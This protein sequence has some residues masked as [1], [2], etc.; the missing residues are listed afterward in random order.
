M[1]V[2]TTYK[3]IR[4]VSRGGGVKASATISRH[5][6]QTFCEGN[7]ANVVISMYQSKSSTGVRTTC[8]GKLSSVFSVTNCSFVKHRQK[9]CRATHFPTHAAL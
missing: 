1:K 5:S 7:T 6:N 8:R 3:L 4:M 2:T 9:K